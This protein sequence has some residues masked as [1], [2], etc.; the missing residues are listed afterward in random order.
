MEIEKINEIIP[1]LK[2]YDVKEQAYST[3]SSEERK[4]EKAISI[5]L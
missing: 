2:K 5:Y 4:R 3:L 1:V